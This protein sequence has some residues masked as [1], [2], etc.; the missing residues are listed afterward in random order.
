MSPS[1]APNS[2]DS[3]NRL[4]PKM[5]A[6]W[7]AGA[8]LTAGAVYALA[9]HWFMVNATNA[10]WT[11]ALL[12]GPLLLAIA[13]MGWQRR[14]AWTMAA[15]AALL[16]VLAVVVWRG[17]VADAQLMYYLQHGAIHA[18]L[19]WSFGLTLR[20]RDSALITAL[21]QGV[22]RRLGQTF[23]PAMADYTRGC[24]WL[25]TLYFMAM[26]LVSTLLYV[27]APWPWWSLYCTVLT[28]LSAGALFV[29]E[30][31][32]RNWRHP[33]FPRVS[34]RAAFEAYQHSGQAKEA[35]P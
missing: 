20:G 22:H 10:A 32:W 31:L 5:S 26:M 18:A 1:T 27:A 13:A 12:F 30:H 16:I 2:L 14:Q 23:T 29:G 24:T 28:P 35:P 9:S 15:C 8:W 11:V 21:A 19:A 33:E 3:L 4:T 6:S 34:L 25:W 7:R 17:G